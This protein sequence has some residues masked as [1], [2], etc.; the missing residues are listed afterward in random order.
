MLLNS[1]PSPGWQAM[2]ARLAL[3]IAL[4]SIE[5]NDVQ[6]QVLGKLRRVITERVTP[7]PAEAPRLEITTERIDVFLT[8]MRP[9]IAH[10][11]AVQTA[12]QAQVAYEAK[13]KQWQAC[14]ERVGRSLAGRAPQLTMAQQERLGALSIRTTELVSAMQSAAAS[15][16]VRVANAVQDSMDMAGMEVLI[17]QYPSLSACGMPA[18]RPLPPPPPPTPTQGEMIAESPGGMT[19][20]QFGRLRELIA[21]YLLTGQE[22]PG[23]SMA[24]QSALGARSKELAP[25]EPLFRSGAL[26]WARWESLGKNWHAK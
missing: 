24:E 10:A 17:V 4:L 26:E 15:G 19:G 5:A 13:Q 2:F 25:L 18:P 21:V 9:V 8:A 20:T 11:V 6:A 1:I 12:M 7:R 16:N 14:K 3:L 23:F 22:A